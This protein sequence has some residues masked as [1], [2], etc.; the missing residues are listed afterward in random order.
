MDEA[1][2][3]PRTGDDA[4]CKVL[5]VDDN[6]DSAQSMSLLLGLEGYSVECAYDGEEALARADTFA[7]E[8]VLLDLGLPR[9]SGY[10]VATRL[11]SAAEAS[12]AALL[13]V[14]VSGYGRDQDRKAA[15]EAGF[16]LHLTKPADPDEVLRVLA[17]RRSFRAAG[18]SGAAAATSAS[19]TDRAA[20]PAS[21]RDAP[22]AAAKPDA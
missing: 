14:A 9:I 2:I 22:G 13:L 19:V 4:A 11:R 3:D 18:R 12:G 6:V 7:P 17:D 5:V 21:T 15:R 20:E 10:E 1:G 8:V 16:D